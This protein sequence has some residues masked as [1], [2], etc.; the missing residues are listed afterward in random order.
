MVSTVS[1][2]FIKGMKRRSDYSLRAILQ[3]RKHLNLAAA[4]CAN[5]PYTEV[6]DKSHFRQQKPFL[7]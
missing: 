1:S 6:G 2:F 5:L 7:R 3:S 4:E